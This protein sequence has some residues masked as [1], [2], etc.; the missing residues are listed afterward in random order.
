[1]KEKEILGIDIGG[2][3]I[4][5]AVVNITKGKMV[6]DRFRIPTP[7]PATPEVVTDIVGQIAEHFHWKGSVGSGFPGVIQ[8]GIVKTAA[9]LDNSW[10]GKNIN[11]LFSKRTG[12]T[13]HVVNDA[14]AAGM[15]EMKFGAGKGIKGTVFLVTVGTGLGTALF[16][17]GK[18]VANTELG[19]VI[20]N[21][22]DAEKYAADSI[23]KN[24]NLD[25]DVWGSRLNEYFN[26]MERLLWPDLII[27]GGGVSKKE[28]HYK[29]HLTLKTK[30]VPAKLLNNAG[31]IGAALASKYYTKLEKKKDRK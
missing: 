17:E 19:H 1:M 10:I 23:R 11:E 3:G 30:I 21:G 29:K 2:T 27:I 31:I 28:D 6:T 4:K 13:T 8:H 9:N 12:C 14:D 5:G 15:A 22:R 18:L 16:T 26:K 24:E 20:L 25:W 7:Q